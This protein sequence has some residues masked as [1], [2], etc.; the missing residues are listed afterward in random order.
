MQ[1]T[2]QESVIK[3]KVNASLGQSSTKSNLLR[4]TQLLNERFLLQWAKDNHC[5][6]LEVPVSTIG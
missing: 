2:L 5:D 1:S 3:S 6:Y 4:G